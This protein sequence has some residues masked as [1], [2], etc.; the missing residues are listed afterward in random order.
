[1]TPPSKPPSR[2]LY[3]LTIVLGAF[4]L[5]LVQPMAARAILPWFGGTAAVWITCLVFFQ[6]ALFAGYLYAHGLI[7]FLGPRGQ[8]GVHMALMAAALATL[9]VNPS[10]AWKPLGTEDPGLR[11][12]GLLSVSVGLPY[13]LLAATS[14]LLQAWY[15]RTRP[16]GIPWRL[17]ALSN[18]GSLAALLSYPFA[19]EPV[20]GVARQLH[21]WS[22]SFAVFALFLAAVAWSS[23]RPAAVLRGPLRPDRVP[24]PPRLDAVHWVLLSACASVLLMAVSSHLTQNVAAI[25]FLWVLPLGLYLLTFIL[26]FDGSG[27]YRRGTFVPAV[28]FAV[29]A[30]TLLL[31]PDLEALT[32]W[33][34][35]PV[36]AA[37][38]FVCCMVCH[39]EL[40]LLRP[41]PSHLTAFYLCVAA[42][43][44]LGGL[45]VGLAA[46]RVFS[47]IW[48][49]PLG[50]SA[51]VLL[52]LAALWRRPPERLGPA[53]FRPAWGL[54]AVA[55]VVSVAG[56][57][58]QV[59]RL[60]SSHVVMVRDFYGGFRVSERRTA[61]GKEDVR[62]LLHG[63]I[64]H[65]EQF[66]DPVRRRLPTS[67]YGLTSGAA[68]AITREPRPRRQKVGVIGLGSGTLAA[69]GRDGDQYR[70]YEL[71][72]LIVDLAR[73][74]FTWLADSPARIEVVVGDAR[75]ALEREPDQQFDVLFVDAFSGDSIPTH[76][77]TREAFA[78][79]RRHL[80]IGGMMAIHITNRYMDLGPVVAQGA[81][82]I[83][84][85][86]R[87]VESAP[88]EAHFWRGSTWVLLCDRPESIRLSAG[89]NTGLDL[90]ADPRRRAW[91]DDT[92]DLFGV[93]RR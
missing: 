43:G 28:F 83:G 54:T 84:L 86:A 26:C 49:L 18:A 76:L 45:F 21:L 16:E 55:A 2:L 61:G 93:L 41:H 73:T 17:F 7:R 6:V 46:P 56:L 39:G 3:G 53:L 31:G 14:P 67:Y 58:V 52:L 15:V 51:C 36:F 70:F 44:A 65:G 47:G 72:P 87:Q 89:S 40:A 62:M 81:S 66:L 92:S 71:S 11:I 59:K 77:L 88:D 50:L 37:G 25:P 19:F 5:F 27:W 68:L 63:V 80:R 23:A 69:Y 33:I 78:L 20:L 10:S 4:L 22:A 38:L 1:M 85:K 57:E 9:P 34:V 24:F 48:E 74:R 13:V 64:N 8:A 79:Y 30:M 60:Q 91:T 90:V 29:W 82:D 32:L 35:L 75:L 42:G 12:L